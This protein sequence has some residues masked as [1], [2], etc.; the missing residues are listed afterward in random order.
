[1]IGKRGTAKRDSYE[2]ELNPELLGEMIRVARKR[3]NLTQEQLG[4][5]I[6][7][8]KGPY[9]KIGGEC[10]QCEAAVIFEK[11]IFVHRFVN[12]DGFGIRKP[13]SDFL[14]TVSANFYEIQ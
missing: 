2:F 11:A 1:M 6:R 12:V 10:K 9:F 5:L 13:A 3:R 14:R 4:N 7:V 8:Q